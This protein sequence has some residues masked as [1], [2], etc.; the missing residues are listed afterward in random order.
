[1]ELDRG[2]VRHI[3]NASDPHV[4]IVVEVETCVDEPPARTWEVRDRQLREVFGKNYSP[5]AIVP[6]ELGGRP[7]AVWTYSVREASGSALYK[8][9]VRAER[10]GNSYVVRFCAPAATYSRW[11]GVFNHVENSFRFAVDDQ[12]SGRVVTVWAKPEAG[13]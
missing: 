11:Q 3:Y 7:A 10:L 4:S 13:Q 2:I 1:M 12:P 9:D 6:A 5:G 8:R